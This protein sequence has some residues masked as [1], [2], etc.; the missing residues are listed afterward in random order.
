M[1]PPATVYTSDRFL[2]ALA[3]SSYQASRWPPSTLS[4]IDGRPPPAATTTSSSKVTVTRT[5]E[6]GPY[7]PL[8]FGDETDTV[9]GATV[10]GTMLFA[11][12]SEPSDPG[13]GSPRS[14]AF[15]MASVMA[16]RDV[17]APECAYSRPAAERA[18]SPGSTV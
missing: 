3:P 6:P 4:A 8:P 11:R 17:K 14:T 9:R 15:P 13:S 16:P 18:A 1:S 12:P 2:P 7:A 10:S 5:A